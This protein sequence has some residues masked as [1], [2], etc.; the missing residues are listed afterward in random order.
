M[1]SL[2]AIGLDLATIFVTHSSQ[3]ITINRDRPIEFFLTS[4]NSP[5]SFKLTIMMIFS[6]YFVWYVNKRNRNLCRKII[7]DSFGL[8]KLDI[9]DHDTQTLKLNLSKEQKLEYSM[10]YFS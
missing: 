7:I 2:D 10:L 8:T 5:N 6:N 4:D 9:D 3:I 1:K